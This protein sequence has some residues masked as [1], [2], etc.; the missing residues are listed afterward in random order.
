[1]L[2]QP[3]NYVPALPISWAEAKRTHS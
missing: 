1:M 3:V 2:V